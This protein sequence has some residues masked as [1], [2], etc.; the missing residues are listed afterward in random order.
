MPGNTLQLDTLIQNTQE[1]P[2]SLTQTLTN[3]NIPEAHPRT[4]PQ[5]IQKEKR[6]RLEHFLALKREIRGGMGMR[7]S[8]KWL[9]SFESSPLPHKGLN[10]WGDDMLLWRVTVA[11]CGRGIMLLMGG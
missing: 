1:P 6:N 5:L 8:R 4:K 10:G 7:K 2:K 11:L 3:K 9:G